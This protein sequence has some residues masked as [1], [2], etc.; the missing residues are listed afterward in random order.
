MLPG[1]GVATN[2]ASSTTAVPTPAA[3]PAIAARISRGFMST[4]GK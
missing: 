3:P 1:D 4:Y 2:P